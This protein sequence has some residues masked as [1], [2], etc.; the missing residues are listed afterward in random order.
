MSLSSFENYLLHQVTFLWHFIHFRSG[1]G[2]YN[3][4]CCLE[5]VLLRRKANNII[6]QETKFS[7]RFTRNDMGRVGLAEQNKRSWCNYNSSDMFEKPLS[8]IDSG[9][10]YPPLLFTKRSWRVS[11]TRFNC[12]NFKPAGRMFYR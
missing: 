5:D 8:L 6:L 7:L 9:Q 3:L 11:E 12:R 2:S 1:T 4:I 10:L